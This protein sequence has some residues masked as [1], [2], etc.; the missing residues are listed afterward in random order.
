MDI[1]EAY[2]KLEKEIYSLEGVHKS[3]MFTITELEEKVNTNCKDKEL[4]LKCIEILDIAQKALQQKMKEGFE[5]VSTNALQSVFGIGHELEL[6]FDRR[7]A[8]PEA[9]VF[10]KTPDMQEPHEPD[11]S[12]AGGQ[13]DLIA[14]ILRIVVLGFVQPDGGTPLK[15]DEPF[16]QIDE[17]SILHVGKCLKS[18]MEKFDRQIILITHQ[19]DLLEFGDNCIEF[20]GGD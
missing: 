18:I 19:K 20:K 14:L 6:D 2:D 15:L 1:F 13:K 11:D 8:I 12:N 10:I 7:G 9:K 4:F 16:S 5:I 3:L 17:N